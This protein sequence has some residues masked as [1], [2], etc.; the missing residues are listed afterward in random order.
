MEHLVTSTGAQ[1]QA[2]AISRGEM[3]THLRFA[4]KLTN[5]ELGSLQSMGL[6]RVETFIPKQLS[7]QSNNTR[8]S[9]K[10]IFVKQDMQK[11]R[12]S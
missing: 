3:T 2:A 11:R 12:R 7:H 1:S 9:Q 6:Q 8:I 5:G 10:K 4:W